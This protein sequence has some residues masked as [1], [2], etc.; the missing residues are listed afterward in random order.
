MWCIAAFLWA[1]P[2]LP[3]KH[4]RKV[5]A[6]LTFSSTSKIARKIRNSWST[7]DTFS[8]KAWEP[9]QDTF[10]CKALEPDQTI[11][12]QLAS[13]AEVQIVSI[14]RATSHRCLLLS[15]FKLQITL[16]PMLFP[17]FQCLGLGR[18]VTP[19]CC[20]TKRST[21]QGGIR[22]VYICATVTLRISRKL[23]VAANLINI[24]VDT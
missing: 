15:R 1:L 10:S 2:K 16:G 23:I 11:L 9:D 8:Y 19:I 24:F 21:E 20:E 12:A 22:S 18:H 13:L 6:Y 4:K 14:Q 17:F 7:S 3:V 5:V